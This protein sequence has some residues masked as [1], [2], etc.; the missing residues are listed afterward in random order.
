MPS[1]L[2][3]DREFTFSAARFNLEQLDGIVEDGYDV[4]CSCPT[5]GYMLKKVLCNGAFFSEEYQS[6]FRKVVGEAGGDPCQ[7][8]E[9]MASECPGS[10]GRA[11]PPSPR[12]KPPEG[13]AHVLSAALRDDGYFRSLSGPRRIAVASHTYDLGEYLLDLDQRGELN[14]D[15]GPLPDRMAYY[16]PC[17][18]KEQGVGQPWSDLVALVPGAS[19][20]K[21]GGPYDCCG[22]GGIMGLKREFHEASLHMGSRLMEAIV[23]KAPRR[24]ITDCLS[25]RIQF[26]QALPYEVY[27]PV[28]I[29]REAYSRRL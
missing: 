21:V 7:A 13:F 3:G 11:T 28:E 29:L 9:R 23:A 1:L 26:N 18:L 17:H 16:A 12:C 4:V 27:H 15:L 2:E 14:R 5:C 24:L 22:M 19:L 20:E 8:R 10:G 6:A 25:C